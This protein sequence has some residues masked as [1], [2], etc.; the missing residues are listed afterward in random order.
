MNAGTAPRTRPLDL[1]VLSPLAVGLAALTLA[2]G[3]AVGVGA[4]AWII[5]GVVA[6]SWALALGARLGGSVG[7]MGTLLGSFWLVLAVL[8]GTAALGVPMVPVAAVAWTALGLAGCLLLNAQ[9]PAAA[10]FRRWAVV[11]LPALSGSAAWIGTLLVAQVIPGAARV[12]WVMAGDS[13][14]NV[15]FAREV[16]ERNGIGFG[17]G[18]NPVPLPAGMLG[19]TMA[20]GRDAVDPADLLRHDITAFAQVWGLTVALSCFV[21]GLV[22]ALVVRRITDRTLAIALAGGGASLLPLSWFLTGYPFEFGFFTAQLALPLVLAAFLAFLASERRPALGLAVQMIAGSVVLAVWSPLVVMPAA[23]G[24]IILVRGFRRILATRGIELAVLIVALVQLVAFGLF[25]VLPIL[26]DSASFLTAGGGAFAFRKWIVVLLAGVV[27]VGALAAFRRISDPVVLGAAGMVLG[28]GAGLGALLFASSRGSELW[29]Y[30][31]TKYLWLTCTVL[32]VLA[33]AMLAAVVARYLARTWML[34]VGAV[35][36]GGLAAGFLA[37]TP[38]NGSGYAWMNPVERVARG[39]MFGSDGDRVADLIFQFSDPEQ[40][41]LLWQTDEAWGD[42]INFW[43]L[44]MWSRTMRDN[45]ELKLAAY[46]LYD[47][48]DV[49]ELCRIVDLL[50]GGTIVHTSQ[51]GLAEQVEAECPESGIRVVAWEG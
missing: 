12:S 40:S 24:A 49:G 6:V 43:V 27:A 10:E 16:V 38:Q 36:I 46:G 13:A 28:S 50:G 4:P 7:L 5:F 22:A 26:V 21:A 1:R 25:S 9:P 33:V 15:L 29:S 11:A 14:N 32:V 23:L 37:L 35:A 41:H 39:E 18:E 19:I 34:V 44:H 31:P 17:V 8:A 48:E 51:S 42:A 3:I 30:Y 2:A 47:H 45:F 20:G